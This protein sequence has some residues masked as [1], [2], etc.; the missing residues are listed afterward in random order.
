[1][2]VNRGTEAR[3]PANYP[4]EFERIEAAVD[5]GE[6]DLRALGF[7]RLLTKVK[8][9]QALAAHW[10]G[11]AGRI[12][13]RAFETGIDEVFAIVR[14]GNERSS[15]VARRLGMEYVGRTDKY[16]GLHAELFRLRPADLADAQ[17][18]ARYATR[19]TG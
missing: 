19:S 7:W 9:D 11:P 1:M 18:I 3:Q 14:P 5:A 6:T 4:A 10:A 2:S 8:A 12:D 15:Q 13:R 17:E 16:W